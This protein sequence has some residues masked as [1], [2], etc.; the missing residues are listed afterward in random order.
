MLKID[1]LKEIIENIKV[2]SY[3]FDYDIIEEILN[4]E[5]SKLED[6]YGSSDILKIAFYGTKEGRKDFNILKMLVLLDNYESLWYNFFNNKES[7]TSCN[8]NFNA[9]DIIGLYLILLTNQRGKSIDKLYRDKTIIFSDISKSAFMEKVTSLYS[10]DL[11]DDNLLLVIFSQ[12]AIS[13]PYILKCRDITINHLEGVVTFTSGFLDFLIPMSL[14]NLSVSLYGFIKSYSLKKINFSQCDFSYTT[15]KRKTAAFL[16]ALAFGNVLASTH[17]NLININEIPSSIFSEI[18]DIFNN[19]FDN[20]VF[21]K[22]QKLEILKSAILNNKNISDDYKSHYLKNL[23][24]FIDSYDDINYK[25]L[26]TNIRNL[27][28]IDVECIIKKGHYTALAFNNRLNNNIYDCVNAYDHDDEN[29]SGAV[30]SHE[31]GHNLV[32]SN[33]GLIKAGIVKYD[34]SFIIEGFNS[35]NQYENFGYYMDAY[36]DYIII[37]KYFCELLG[38]D[39]LKKA[40]YS[41]NI[42]I[43]ED[44]LREIDSSVN[45]S[46]F[47]SLLDKFCYTNSKD[48]KTM[49]ISAMELYLEK[50]DIAVEN[51][52]YARNYIEYLNGDI[53][54][55][56]EKGY[57]SEEYIEKTKNESSVLRRIYK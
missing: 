40:Y 8:S 18:D 56:M 11:F 51:K 34:S 19:P 5:E 47:L 39:I 23:E 25:Q 55:V 30:I 3:H 41:G 49:V 13:F 33:F 12:L 44:A 36:D 54:F 50:A 35:L 1:I 10:S 31:I 45:A 48:E 15:W 52:V 20:K 26:Y 6:I 43:L 24:V 2:S 46:R 57:L 38:A 28:V 32:F 16:Y 4:N 9:N 37:N 29:V 7:K 22:S 42:S 17:V 21:T 53:D 27:D 14:A